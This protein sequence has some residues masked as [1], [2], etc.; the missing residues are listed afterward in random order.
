MNDPFLMV[1]LFVSVVLLLA[2][3]GLD[4]LLR[5]TW[6][7]QRKRLHRGTKERQKRLLARFGRATRYHVD[8]RELRDFVISLQLGTSMEETLSGAL[9]AAAEQFKGRG[10]FGKRLFKH[11]ETR[12]S[13]APEEVIKGLAEDFQSEHLRDLAQRLEMARDGGISYERALS[14]TVSQL[15]EEI[16]GDLKRDIQMTPIQLTFPMIIGVFLPAVLIGMYPL[17]SQLLSNILNLRVGP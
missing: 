16:R 6:A 9:S 1:V 2:A 12:L 10:D 13:I 5:R 17:I 8:L 3:S 7:F 11:V 4:Y 14:L 15:E